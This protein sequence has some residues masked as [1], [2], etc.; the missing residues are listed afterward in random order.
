M[1]WMKIYIKKKKHCAWGED[2]CWTLCC[3]CQSDQSG[4][5]RRR[6]AGG[7]SGSGR[8]RTSFN[9]ITWRLE[10]D[11]F[12][13]SQ[14]AVQL[15]R[16]MFPPGL[17][18]DLWA[19]L[20]LFELWAGGEALREPLAISAMW[21]HRY[22]ADRT[23]SG[24][25]RYNSTFTWT[26][27]YGSRTKLHHLLQSDRHFSGNSAKTFIDPQVCTWLNF[28][29]THHHL[30][31]VGGGRVVFSSWHQEHKIRKYP[32]NASMLYHFWFELPVGHMTTKLPLS[33]CFFHF[34][35]LENR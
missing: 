22:A 27:K 34:C 25:V 31:P 29:L 3:C 12:V 26:P 35:H 32:T 16:K 14:N 7:P 30:G 11:G 13:G 15:W 21:R 8:S 5:T 17:K 10:S 6:G 28:Y 24:T 2:A 9:R 19:G 20:S 33:L 1:R 18:R 23:N 4:S